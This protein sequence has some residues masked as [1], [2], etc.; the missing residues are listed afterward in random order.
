MQPD[1][2]LRNWRQIK[3]NEH[4]PR[5]GQLFQDF[6]RAWEV[7]LKFIDE[8]HLGPVGVNLCELT[9]INNIDKEAGWSELGELDR[10]FPHL[11]PLELGSFLPPP[12]MLTWQARYRLPEGRGRLYAE[13]NPIFRGRDMKLVLSL[14][15]TARGAPAGGSLEQISAWFELSHEWIIRAFVDLTGPVAHEF[16]GMKL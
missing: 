16:W 12:E 7:F 10:V 4:Y 8:E 15:L 14:N 6:K 13:M 1:R 11:R 5:F 2:F 9:Y 3:G